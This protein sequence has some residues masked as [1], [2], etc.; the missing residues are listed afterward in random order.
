MINAICEYGT[1]IFGLLLI[2]IALDLSLLFFHLLFNWK[3]LLGAW[4]KPA[5]LASV[6]ICFCLPTVIEWQRRR[7]IANFNGN[8]DCCERVL[9]VQTFSCDNKVGNHSEATKKALEQATSEVHNGEQS[10]SSSSLTG[11]R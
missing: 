7:F 10:L 8:D 2:L 11:G 3:F 9:T 4:L 6:V 1:Y 5:L